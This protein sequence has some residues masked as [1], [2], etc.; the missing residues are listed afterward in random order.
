MNTLDWC[1]LF[2]T[3]VFIVL[4]GTWKTRG[5][6]NIEGYLKGDNSMRWWMM[7]V[8][9][10][11]TQASAVTFLS[12]PG[13]AIEDGMRFLQFYFG[14]PIA[15]VII[16]VT[17]V[18]IYYK[19][20]VFTAYEYLES[21]FDLKTRL[22][23]AILFLILR[24]LSA[25]ITLF[26]P[27]LVLSTILGW[28]T[29]VTT[30]LIGGFVIIYVT[31]GG[32]KA[33]SL[34]QR[35]QMAV[36]MGGMILAGILAYTMLPKNVSFTDTVK[37]A[38]SLGRMNI[39]NTE[40]NLNDRYNIWSGLIAGTFLFLSYF[41]T[42]QSQVSRYLTGT[43]ITESR[44]GLIFNGLLK[45]PMQ[46]MILFIGVL[47]FVFY[48]FNQPPVFHNVVLKERAQQTPQGQQLRAYEQQY[49]AL[50]L[51]KRQSVDRLV[52]AIQHDDAT[53]VNVLKEEVKGLEARERVLRDSVRATIATAV[54][55]AKVQD[56]DYIFLNFVLQHLP[57]GIIGLL[58]AVIFS[59]A[60]SSMAG[61]L[62]ALA[63]TTTVDIYKRSFKAEASEKHYLRASQGFTVLWALLAMV[64]AMLATFAENLI[65]FVNIVGSLFYG[66]ILGIF[67]TAF[68]LKRV[69]SNA[70]FWAAIIAEAVVLFCYYSFREDIAFLLYNVIG[71][72]V[73]IIL[74]L[75][76]QVFTKR[77]HSA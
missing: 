15:M 5:N 73:V 71:C 48:L 6:K 8:S 60:M 11:A 22:L 51:E 52:D 65:Q 16:S 69:Q 61:E 23:A 40:F 9:I 26:A 44:L 75:I 63:S 53:Q 24:G 4:Y 20:K 68:Y 37:L 17:M 57:N 25:G 55:G 21:R 54:P 62:N 34:T 43:S 42:D 39:I 66:T 13:Q 70:V 72:G 41:G 46:F 29:P 64:F 49:D 45:I 35:Q 1:I 30:I 77:T 32:T 56:R 27:A 10:M 47:V 59:A 50:F 33:V 31:V 67:L 74:A 28:S 2:G 58:L 7:G 12:T 3:L 76:F 38:G 14:L 36:I 19:L 18:P